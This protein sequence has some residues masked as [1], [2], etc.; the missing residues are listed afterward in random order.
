ML[1]IEAGGSVS[2][3]DGHIGFNAGSTGTATVSGAGSNWTNSGSLFVG[4]S[5][6]GTLTIEAG[7]Q[8]G[9]SA[10][11]LGYKP[12]SSGTATVTGSGAAWTS[13]SLAVGCLGGGRL[14]VA[15]GGLV[16]A[17]TIHAS[18][19]NLYGNGTIAVNGVV[20]DADADLW[21]WRHAEFDY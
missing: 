15:N 2:N 10:S 12:G 17:R 21:Q 20:L 16:T 18:P 7:A 3:S 5:G 1:T 14:T 13:E 8:V 6:S 9:N 19:I 4:H 11:Y